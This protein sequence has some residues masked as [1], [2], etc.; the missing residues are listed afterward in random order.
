MK[1]N[2]YGRR[3]LLAAASATLFTPLIARGEPQNKKIRTLLA[4]GAVAPE[5]AIG[6]QPLNLPPDLV[7]ALRAGAQIRARV[8]YPQRRNLLVFRAFL[9]APGDP[10]PP[11]PELRDNDPRLFAHLLCEIQDVH[12]S[13]FPEMSVGLYGRILTEIKPSP[14]FPGLTGRLAAVQLGHQQEGDTA[15]SMLTVS[16]AGDHVVVAREGR[17]R[18]ELRP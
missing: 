12:L 14:F 15:I 8:E 13:T 16:A 18:I 2:L 9:A 3:S 1:P 10:A 6:E 4:E 17:G 5:T 11:L 7:A